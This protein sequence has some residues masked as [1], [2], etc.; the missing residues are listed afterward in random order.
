MP[1][2]LAIRYAPIVEFAQR[3]RPASIPEVGS[4]VHGI[5]Y[6]L[7]DRH[8][9]GSDLKF[10]ERPESNMRAVAS[11]A[12]VLPFRNRSF[13]L[14]ISSDMMEHLPAAIRG[15]VV[16]EML[17][18]SRKHVV[19]GFPSGRIAQR[20]DFKLRE[21]LQRRGVSLRS[22]EEHVQHEYPT[23]E[24]ILSSVD[25]DKFRYW[26]LR[27][28]NWRVHWAVAFLLTKN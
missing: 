18:V 11:T 21:T 4:G 27:N 7:K 3:E 24:S 17:R 5:A 10:R 19:I 1:L 8:I 20:H 23:S 6:Y 25:K 15:D 12:E 28:A 9:V 26:I 14:V 2:D 16:K 22:L 13:D